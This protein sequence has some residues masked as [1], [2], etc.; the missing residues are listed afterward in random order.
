MTTFAILDA[1]GVVTNLAEGLS[2]DDFPAQI[3]VEIPPNQT[4]AIGW[5]YSAQVGL[6]DPAPPP[7]ALPPA[8]VVP[9][10]VARF[11]AKVALLQ[12]G[13][14]DNVEAYMALPETSRVTKMAWQEAQEFQRQSPTVLALAQLLGMTDTQLD[15]LFI[16]AAKVKA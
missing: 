4:P 16:F 11:Q 7:P 14:L 15:D 2:K 3:A 8:R 10:S 9:Q 6:S 12:A 1:Q 13:H 5:V